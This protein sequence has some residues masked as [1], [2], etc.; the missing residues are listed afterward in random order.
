MITLEEVAEGRSAMDWET[1][2]ERI[3]FQQ[4]IDYIKEHFT[5]QEKDELCAQL[6]HKP[7]LIALIRGIPL[8]FDKSS[9][10]SGTN[11]N[12][13]GNGN[14]NVSDEEE[15]DDRIDSIDSFDSID[16]I[17]EEDEEDNDDMNNKKH[18][19]TLQEWE[20][21]QK[22][23]SSTVI[24]KRPIRPVAIRPST[25]AKRARDEDED[26]GDGEDD[27]DDEDGDDDDS[28]DD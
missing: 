1:V 28:S 17:G 14:N 12:K 10:L 11:S 18:P 20:E 5:S 26:E 21:M 9:T 19:T 3:E 15:D 25:L 22:Q 2:Y 8:P 6:T 13:N 27:E 23:R 7:D 24:Q 16:A 4:A